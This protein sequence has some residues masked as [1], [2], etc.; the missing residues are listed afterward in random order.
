MNVTVLLHFDSCWA[1][2]ESRYFST[3]R[4]SDNYNTK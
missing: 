1:L 4:W 2:A 3:S